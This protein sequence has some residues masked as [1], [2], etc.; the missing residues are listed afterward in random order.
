MQLMPAFV[1]ANVPAKVCIFLVPSEISCPVEL[2]EKPVSVITPVEAAL[3]I[4]LKPP[5]VLTGPLKV[6]LAIVLVSVSASTVRDI[7]YCMSLY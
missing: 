3:L 4:T 1:D 7:V 5:S 6:E 2:T